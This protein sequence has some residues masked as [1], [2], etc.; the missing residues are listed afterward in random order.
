[1]V[2]THTGPR[3]SHTPPPT[4]TTTNNNNN[5][6]DDA[7]NEHHDLSTEIETEEIFA[8]H[9]EC[10]EC[11]LC[12][13]PSSSSIKSSMQNI[14]ENQSN[15]NEIKRKT[16]R[17]LAGIPPIEPMA[18]L[19]YAMVAELFDHLWFQLVPSIVP[20]LRTVHDQLINFESIRLE[21]LEKER[22]DRATGGMDDTATMLR[23]QSARHY[24]SAK[25]EKQDKNA[26]RLSLA[27]TI[28][29]LN[30]H[31]ISSNTALSARGVGNGS[32]LK[33]QN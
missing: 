21:V 17:E 33:F 27:M 25:K 29:S 1:M 14:I 3:D 2:N 6:D 9:G 20:F 16:D 7:E 22:K 30:P 18:C 13:A 15:K 11:I 5:N 23:I 32:T 26:L 8:S 31:S 10:S 12:D 4:T 24:S 19:R 28:T